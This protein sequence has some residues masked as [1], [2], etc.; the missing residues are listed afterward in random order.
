[1]YRL[2]YLKII[3]SLFA[4]EDYVYYINWQPTNV[5]S[6]GN[7]RWKFTKLQKFEKL[8]CIQVVRLIR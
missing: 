7:E 2:G 5:S 8:R 3:V 6:N 1:M 4:M